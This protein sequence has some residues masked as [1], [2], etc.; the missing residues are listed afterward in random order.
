MTTATRETNLAVNAAADAKAAL[1][2][3][4]G[5]EFL[6][7]SP[8]AQPDS[9]TTET[10]LARVDF[11]SFAPAENGI[12]EYAFTG[13]AVQVEGTVGWWRTVDSSEAPVLDGP[14]YATGD[15]PIIGGLELA[16]LIFSSGQVLTGTFRYQQPKI[17]A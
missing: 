9:A 15:T 7:G 2:T 6:T 14:V 3:G 17:A 1:M 16:S 13:V 10:V 4:G 5:L 11:G 12:I 8:S